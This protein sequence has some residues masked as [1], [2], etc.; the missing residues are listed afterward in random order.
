MATI[1]FTLDKYQGLSDKVFSGLE[2]AILDG[3]ILPGQKIIEVEIA[4]QLGISKA[5]VREALK[6]LEA[7]G[8]VEYAPRKGFSVKSYNEKNIR[9][10]F[11][12]ILVIEEF[13]LVKAIENKT[14]ESVLLLENL[15]KRMYKTAEELDYETYFEIND[16]FHNYFDEFSKNEWG[17][18]IS[19]IL[20]TQTKVLRSLALSPEIGFHGSILEHV[21]M[22]DLYR[23]GDIKELVNLMTI[24]QLRVRD[25]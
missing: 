14:E 7:L 4:S 24:H 11:D 10:L 17:Y 18:R 12:F 13:I 16:D 8:V 2:Q 15:L 25:S 22:V 23:A 9:D 1:D 3:G 6:R 20:R 21:K 19:K 5:P